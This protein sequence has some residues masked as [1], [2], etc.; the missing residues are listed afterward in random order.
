MLV[1]SASRPCR[2]GYAEHPAPALVVSQ[3]SPP[4]FRSSWTLEEAQG[5]EVTGVLCSSLLLAA[6]QQSRA[7]RVTLRPYPLSTGP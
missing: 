1:T 7:V 6:T 3:E 2:L 5:P 4:E